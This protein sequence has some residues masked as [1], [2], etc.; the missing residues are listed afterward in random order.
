[1]ASSGKTGHWW[2]RPEINGSPYLVG[3]VE[4]EKRAQ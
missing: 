2:T 3:F 1:L 4:H